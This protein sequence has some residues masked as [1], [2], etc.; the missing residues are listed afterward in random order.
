MQ[1]SRLVYCLA[2]PWKYIRVE[3]AS[4]QNYVVFIVFVN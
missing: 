4:K 3:Y 1:G 2:I